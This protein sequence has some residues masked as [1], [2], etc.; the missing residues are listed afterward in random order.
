MSYRGGRGG[1]R[2]RGSRG[3][4]GHVEELPDEGWASNGSPRTAAQLQEV[5]LRI[6]GASYPQYRCLEGQWK[7]PEFTLFFDRIQGDPYAPPTR[8]RVRVQMDVARFP[9]DLL[10][11]STRRIALSDFLNRS[12]WA[13]A[14]RRGLDESLGGQGGGGRSRR[15]RM[16]DVHWAR[17]KLMESSTCNSFFQ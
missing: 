15:T 4:Y 10:S 16:G 6:D 8:A 2:G 7:F 12:F 11:T 14:H 1:G 9:L 13:H 5:L 17:V 3:G